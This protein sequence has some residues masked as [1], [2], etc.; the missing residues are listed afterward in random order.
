[1]QD[2]AE[3]SDAVLTSAR[4]AGVA[5]PPPGQSDDGIPHET[6]PRSGPRQWLGAARPLFFA[7]LVGLVVLGIHLL[8]LRAGAHPRSG[9]TE[10]G[11]HTAAMVVAA[12]AVGAVWWARRTGRTW[13]SDLLPALFAGLAGLTMLT[14]LHGTPFD[15]YGVQGDQSFRTAMVTRFADTW[16]IVDYT[17]RD[18]PG[19]YAPGY[20][21]LLGRAAYLTGVAPWHILKFGAIAVA[22]AVPLVSYL[23][24]RRLV[25]PRHAALISAVPLIV[26]DLY[27]S[28][29][30]VV[31]LAVIPWWLE[32]VHGLTRS[33]L[34]RR[35]PVVLGLIGAVLFCIY[36]Y[37]FFLFV[38]V[39]PLFL[40]VQ[41]WRGEFD[42]RAAGRGL[43]VLGIA[44]LGSAVFW[45]PMAWNFLTA[46]HFE[47]LNNRWITLNSGDL[48]LPML[49]PTVVGALCL[50][51]LGYLVLTAREGLSRSLLVVLVA[52]YLW[53]ALGFVFL[54]L[55]VPL[56]SFRMKTLVPLV[57]LSA[58][59]LGLVRGVR[60]I[61]GRISVPAMWPVVA[62]GAG[63]L[64]LLVGDGFVNRVV[65]DPRIH[66]AHN[67]TLPDG[68][69]PPFHD[70]DKQPILP[71]A[72]RVDALIQATYRGPGHPVVLSDR[73]H[74]FTYQPY[75][76]FVQW[77]ANYS[78]PTAQYHRRLEFLEE[79]AGSVSP[80]EFAA[81]T[82]D[83][84]Y[85]RI[86][87]IVLRVDGDD[88]VY[89]TYDDDFPFG[90]KARTVTIP[91]RLV[92]SEHFELTEIDGYL[93]AVRR[94]GGA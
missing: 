69:L 17:Y 52:L 90:T 60:W 7:G 26:P 51:G 75:Y 29:G 23:F 4:Q 82:G 70:T 49:E 11:L 94:L 5:L 63:L 86:D 84:P 37:Y 53:H 85:D 92:T 74:L 31:Q 64:A 39:F 78:H 12:L 20:F 16:Q 45:A 41:W 57:L 18:L 8:A 68:T 56:M 21:W 91:S 32:A 6:H 13:D 50:L 47:S 59:A 79:A 34:R 33:G 38:L 65:D 80:V 30:W 14:A 36:Y 77:N 9:R 27:E 81:K 43:L 25:T 40:A 58:A 10:Y 48:A 87:A 76:G 54:A 71:A 3:G 72:T 1:M 42:R 67:E 35:H 55:D 93:V 46:P 28:Y 15:A 19:Y 73:T 89:R 62:V 66:A 22:F 44:A 61:L 83:N 24:W 2:T 88:L